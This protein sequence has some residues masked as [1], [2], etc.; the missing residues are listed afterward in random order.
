M[1]TALSAGMLQQ[2]LRNKIHT[3]TGKRPFCDTSFKQQP[4]VNQ[5]GDV[6]AQQNAE[7]EK[8]KSKSLFKQSADD[9]EQQNAEDE[10]ETS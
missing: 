6:P 2:N 8:V 10:T 9:L 5:N 7:G 3:L 4:L 1:Q